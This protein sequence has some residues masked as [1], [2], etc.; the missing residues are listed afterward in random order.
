MIYEYALK[1]DESMFM[2]RSV[3]ILSRMKRETFLTFLA[4]ISI[5]N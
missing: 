4:D 2:L 5:D 1:S 3:L